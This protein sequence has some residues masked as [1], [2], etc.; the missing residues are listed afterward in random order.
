MPQTANFFRFM[1]Q[2]KI[3]GS[4]VEPLFAEIALCMFF[5]VLPVL[6]SV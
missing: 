6:V 5:N 2:V 4:N 1:D 3:K